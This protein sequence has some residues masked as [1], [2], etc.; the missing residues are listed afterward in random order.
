MVAVAVPS[1]LAYKAFET[2]ATGEMTEPTWLDYKTKL[3]ALMCSFSRL[4][5]IPRPSDVLGSL[6][7][8]NSAL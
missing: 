6:V 2:L 4:P 5:T 3:L 7:C 1:L 8:R